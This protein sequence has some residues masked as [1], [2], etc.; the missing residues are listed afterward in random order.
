MNFLRDAMRNLQAHFVDLIER[1]RL[2]G[3]TSAMRRG[4]S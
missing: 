2:N 4:H 1:L 3:P